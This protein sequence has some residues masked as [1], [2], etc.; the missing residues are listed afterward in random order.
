M[1]VCVC[2]CVCGG[3]GGGGSTS[4]EKISFLGQKPALRKFVSMSETSTCS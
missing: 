3:E 2:V 4:W 1:C